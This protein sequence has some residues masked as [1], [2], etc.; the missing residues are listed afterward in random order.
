LTAGQLRYDGEVKISRRGAPLM[1][2]VR[3]T[4]VQM[5]VMAALT[6][7]VVV[8]RVHRDDDSREWQPPH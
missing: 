3:D 4:G 8:I 1:R 2:T 7:T 5:C 6:A